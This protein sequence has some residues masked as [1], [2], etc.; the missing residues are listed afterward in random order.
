[1]LSFA[2][3][4][5]VDKHGFFKFLGTM[6]GKQIARGAGCPTYTRKYE[7]FGGSDERRKQIS[8]R[9]WSREDT[10][11]LGE[12]YSFTPLHIRKAYKE[13]RD[14]GWTPH[15]SFQGGGFFLNLGKTDDDA[16]SYVIKKLG[17]SLKKSSGLDQQEIVQRITAY[18]VKYFLHHFCDS[19]DVP[20]EG[21]IVVYSNMEVPKLG[22]FRESKPNW[23]S[24]QGGT[25][26]SVWH[27]CAYQHDIFFVPSTYGNI[28][29][30]YRLKKAVKLEDLRIQPHDPKKTCSIPPSP[31]YRLEKDGSLSFQR[32]TS[33]MARRKIVD[34]HSGDVL[35]RRIPEIQYLSYIQF[36]W[37]CYAYAFS[38][39]LGVHSLDVTIPYGW[40]EV[41]GEK[42]LDAYFTQ[43]EQP[44]QGD[45][46]VY[47]NSDSIKHWGVYLS[48][49]LVE[50]KWGRGGVYQHHFFDAPSEYGDVVRCYRLKD[51]LTLESLKEQIEKDYAKHSKK[52]V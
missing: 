23:N 45:L 46:V 24:P 10:A 8:D 7:V 32:T 3:T 47:F 13:T 34:T 11:L 20:E 1:M 6:A 9:C 29:A 51:G 26:E 4:Q 18:G 48:K 15:P 41:G 44:Q 28:A 31:L 30:F 2:E 33:N 12:H 21:D 50:S 37:V 40:F 27:R 35:S 42:I 19:V 5:L 25:V 43:T 36:G 16:I 38:Q 22:V 14:F 17:D 49:G 39:L 52:E